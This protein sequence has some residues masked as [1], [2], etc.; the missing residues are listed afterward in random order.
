MFHH[1]VMLKWK[2]PLEETDKTYIEAMCNRI[3]RELAG[4]ES[5]RFVTNVSDRSAGFSHAF[6]VSFIDHAAH[7]VYQT[8]AVHQ[9]LIERV[10]ALAADLLVLDYEVASGFVQ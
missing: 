3:E 1:V 8:A 9:P 4:I 2:N 7:D 5:M 10:A 6:V